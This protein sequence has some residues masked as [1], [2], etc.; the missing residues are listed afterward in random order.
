MFRVSAP[1]LIVSTA[2]QPVSPQGSDEG[3]QRLPPM[4]ETVSVV[5]PDQKVLEAA[6][7]PSVWTSGCESGAHGDSGS[8]RLSHA[9]AGCLLLAGGGVP[10]RSGGREPGAV[11]GDLKVC[12]A[13]GRCVVSLR[14]VSAPALA[15]PMSPRARVFR[16]GVSG[17]RLVCDSVN[18]PLCGCISSRRPRA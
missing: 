17:Q 9:E 2:A 8:A 7:A 5:L 12:V 16:E 10:Q 1:A 4:L 13:R 6:P 14:V 3:F 18:P 11:H 15:W